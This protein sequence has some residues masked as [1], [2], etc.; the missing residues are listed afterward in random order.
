MAGLG[1]DR[2]FERRLAGL[3]NGGEPGRSRVAVG[4]W[5]VNH[6]A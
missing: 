5:S 2:L 4:G 6:C 1:V 3:I